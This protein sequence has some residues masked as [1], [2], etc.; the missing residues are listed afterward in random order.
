MRGS[1]PK[2]KHAFFIVGIV[3]NTQ[4]TFTN[5]IRMLQNL[6]KKRFLHSYLSYFEIN[7]P[8]ESCTGLATSALQV[9]TL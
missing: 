6:P 1:T 8:N 7:C 4:S 5:K 2:V 3:C 9:C